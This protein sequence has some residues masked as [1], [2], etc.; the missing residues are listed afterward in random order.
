L[1]WVNI[2][3]LRIPDLYRPGASLTTNA[4]GFRGKT[5]VAT[6]VPP[7]K[8]RVICSGD[9]FTMGFGV[10]DDETWCHVLS[11]LDTSLET[12]NM[13]QGGY[14]VDQAYLW[15]KRDGL[16]IDH[17]VQVFAFVTDDFRRMRH[18][19][20]FGYAKPWI[21]VAGKVENVPV[22]TASYSLVSWWVRNLPVLSALHSVQIV[23]GLAER[24]GLRRPSR[25]TSSEVMTVADARTVLLA[26][27]EDLDRLHGSRGTR[28]VLVHLPTRYELRGRHPLEWFD[29]FRETTARLDLTYMNLFEPFAAKGQPAWADLFLAAGEV[30]HPSAAGH[31]TAAGNRLVAE[32]LVKA[33][34]R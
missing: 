10:D 17:H 24:V 11:R 3:N 18:D 20:F 34:N 16:K 7:G 5:E 28:L 12:I 6:A 25:R 29:F 32:L 2:P 8:V 19:Q 26:I 14:G 30:K 31:Y 33:L 22:P 15:Y 9:S 13:G 27:L 23:Q 21:S 1:G 4:R